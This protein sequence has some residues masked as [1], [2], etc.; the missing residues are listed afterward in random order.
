MNLRVEPC[1]VR[2]ILTPLIVKHREER[3]ED[4]G[5][6]K[7]TEGSLSEVAR[8]RGMHKKFPRRVSC[9]IFNTNR[10]G[11][12]DAASTPIDSAP[13][14]IAVVFRRLAQSIETGELHRPL[15]CG[16]TAGN[17]GFVV[18]ET[19]CTVQVEFASANARE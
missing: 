5:L 14:Y 16:L 1:S 6:G 11:S 19:L 4:T 13:I 9:G 18:R 15:F 8:P 17:D 12:V 7:R 3:R 2:K 10:P